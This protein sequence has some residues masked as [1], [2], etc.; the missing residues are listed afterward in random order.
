MIQFE[1]VVFNVKFFYSAEIY[2][3]THI[4]I[5]IYDGQGHFHDNYHFE[6]ATEAEARVHFCALRLQIEVAENRMHTK[7]D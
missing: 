5:S 6:Y 4:K 3:K 2:D 1:N 7:N